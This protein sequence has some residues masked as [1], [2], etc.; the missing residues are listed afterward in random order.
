MVFC[1]F[2][3]SKWWFYLIASANVLLAYYVFK[4]INVMLP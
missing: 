4:A 3:H 1:S 2:S